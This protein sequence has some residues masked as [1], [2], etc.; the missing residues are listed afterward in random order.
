MSVIALLAWATLTTIGAPAVSAAP[1]VG[2]ALVDGGSSDKGLAAKKAAV[3]EALAK[4]NSTFE[5]ATSTV[6]AAANQYASA[7]AAL[8]AAQSALAS[9]N[10]SVIAASVAVDQANAAVTAAQAQAAA[11]GTA[12]AEAEQR[13][14]DTRAAIA[15]VAN[16]VYQGSNF[17]GLNALLT[18]GSPSD[19][20]NRVGYADQIVAAQQQT[21]DTYIA[22]RM[23]AMDS[24]NAANEATALAVT[25]RS[26]AAQAL[27]RSQQAKATA[28]RASDDVDALVSQRQS[29]LSVAQKNKAAT[30]ALYKQLQQESDQVASELKAAA[31]RDR[32]V[33]KKTSTKTKTPTKTPPK[34][35]STGTDTRGGG[36]YG[37]FIMPIHGWKS[38]NFGMRYDPFYHRWQLHAGVDIAAGGGTPIH[39]AKAG[40]VVRAGWYGGYGNYTCIDNGLYHGR[41]IA[42][43]Y[44]HQSRILVHVGQHVSVGQVIGRV[45]ETGAATGYHLHFEVRINGKPVQPLNWLPKCFC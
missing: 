19:V 38:S 15:G 45:G 39:A 36:T 37:Y 5:S 26:E 28:Q 4:A 10:G 14:I 20:L 43:C 13:V 22:A 16:A 25:A 12:L 3:D 42:T 32:A 9:A 18:N 44:G 24:F 30:L 8:P 2:P 34:T 35:G 27:S 17:L 33:A 21:L 6:Q 23:R 7:T 1:T 41:G 31:A 11:A 40:R 29:A